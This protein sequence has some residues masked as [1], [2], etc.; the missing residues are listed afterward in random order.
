MA[1]KYE[2]KLGNKEE[3]AEARLLAYNMRLKRVSYADI[4]KALGVSRT[5]ASTLCQEYIAELSE[6][7]ALDA[8][9][10]ELDK[11]DGIEAVAWKILEDNHVSIQ[12]GKVVML[13]G[14]TITDNEPLFKAIA[15][16]LKISERRAKY[17]GLDTPVKT[18]HV[19]TT[20]T[21]VDASILDLVKQMDESANA[22]INSLG[23]SSQ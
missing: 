3:K 16:I 20:Q 11:L 7:L 10:V 6:P 14:H 18:E 23:D 19:V 13:D 1:K 2:G 15:S 8:R 4:G 9:K 21:G 12:H 5:T 17:L 22:E